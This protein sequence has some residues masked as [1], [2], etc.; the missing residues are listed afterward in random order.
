MSTDAIVARRP[1]L[2]GVLHLGAFFAAIAGIVV[3]LLLAHDARGYVGASI[4]GGSL[5][6]VYGTS[7]FYHRVPWGRRMKNVM[8]RLDHSMIFAL[9]AGTYTPFC[10]LALGDAWGISLLSVAAGIAGAG[11]IVRLAWLNTPRWLATFLYLSVGWVAL[12]AA[13][14]ILQHLDAAPL[15]LLL[16]GGVAY[17]VGGLMYAFRRPDPWPRVFGYHEVF[18]SF[19]VAGSFFHYLAIAVFLLPA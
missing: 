13:T 10:L 8:G 16:L 7:A 14:Q 3:M 12:V 6:L 19:T 11:A 2:R 15:G 1:M 5:I 4:F 17:S 18:H 9:I